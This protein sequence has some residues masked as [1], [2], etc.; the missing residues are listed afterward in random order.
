MLVSIGE[1]EDETS[2]KRSAMLRFL[3]LKM[4]KKMK[5]ADV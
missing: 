3:S 5:I 4:I 2:P 1:T